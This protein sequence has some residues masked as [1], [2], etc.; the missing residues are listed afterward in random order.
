[1]F[2][3]TS[4]TTDTAASATPAGTLVLHGAQATLFGAVGTPVPADARMGIAEAAALAARAPFRATRP[5]AV[6]AGRPFRLAGASPRGSPVR[7]PP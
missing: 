6:S 5:S 7:R 1:M 2:E 3:T 4:S